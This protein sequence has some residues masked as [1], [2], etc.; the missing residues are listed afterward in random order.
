MNLKNYKKKNYGDMKI[1]KNGKLI[2]KILMLIIY[3]Y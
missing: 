2:M 3:Y 1:L